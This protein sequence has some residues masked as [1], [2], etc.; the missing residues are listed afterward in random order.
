MAS[1]DFIELQYKA[2]QILSNEE[3]FKNSLILTWA[4][5]FTVLHNRPLTT[6][7]SS[8]GIP[9]IRKYSLTYTRWG[10]TSSCIL[11]GILATWENPIMEAI[12]FCD[13]IPKYPPYSMVNHYKEDLV[14]ATCGIYS[15]KIGETPDEEYANLPVTA[16]VTNY[17]FILELEKGY[18]AE[19]CKIDSLIVDYS[20]LVSTALPPEVIEKDLKDRYPNIPIRVVNG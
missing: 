19:F 7:P 10:F 14:S 18:R 13:D 16:F 5:T 12:C 6:V 17:G 15:F 2:R 11:S 9:A 4:K 8:V 1:V 3:K 20:L